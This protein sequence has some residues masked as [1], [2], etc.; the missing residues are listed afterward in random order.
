MLL[1]GSSRPTAEH[2]RKPTCPQ[3]GRGCFPEKQNQVSA[4]ARQENSNPI[5]RSISQS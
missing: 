2:L 3:A 5:R 4:P 1:L